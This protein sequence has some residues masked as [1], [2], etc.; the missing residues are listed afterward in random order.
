MASIQLGK[1][2]IILIR[3]LLQV[4]GFGLDHKLNELGNIF[5]ANRGVN[6]M[7]RGII[8]GVLAVGVAGT[9][10]WGYQEHREKNAILLNAENN[11]QRAFHEL[12]YQ[13]DL[14]NDK[15]GTTLAMNSR[16]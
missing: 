14:I 3:S 7:I 15:I 16:H 6:R 11:Y 10:Y 12:T 4:S 1:P 9:A 13:M 2:Y 8:I 5:F